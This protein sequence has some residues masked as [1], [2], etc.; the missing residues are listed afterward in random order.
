[1]AAAALGVESGVAAVLAAAG[2][3][4][5]NSLEGA[6]ALAALFFATDV[7]DGSVGPR[8]PLTLM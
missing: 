1:V 2:G 6:F 5:V 4:L 8:G 3:T 7:D